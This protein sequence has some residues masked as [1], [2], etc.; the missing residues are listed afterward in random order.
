MRNTTKYLV[1]IALLL[2]GVTGSLFAQT[3]W[4]QGEMQVII[5]V[6]QAAIS[7]MK[8]LVERLS[9]NTE[10]AGNAIR[11]YVTA[12]ELTALENAGL[13]YQIEI[14]NLNAWSASFGPRGVPTGYYTL[15]ELNSIA[16]SL[17]LNFP[18]ICTI[19]TLGQATGFYQLMALKISD[20]SS[21]DENEAEVLFDG[22]IHGDEIGG[23]E[24]MIRFARDLC[25]QYGTDPDITELVN[26]REI[27]IYYCVNPYGR[28][29][30]TRYN[31]N[32][33]DINRD[34]G[35]M[36]NGEGNS[37]SAFS[38][39]ETRAYRKL[40]TEN[41]F[42]IHC[43]YHSGTEYISYPWSYRAEPTPDNAMHNYLAALY[44]SSSGYSNIPYAQGYNGMYAING[45]TK[46]FGYG[47]LGSISWS[48]EISL[49]KQ[50][51]S[52][53]IGSY[54]LKNKPSMLNM[55]EYAGYGIE[56]IVTD[57]ISGEPIPATLFIDNLFPFANDPETGD[58]HKFLLSGNYQV[59]V[60]SNGYES[61]II[62]G[63]TISSMTATE[64]NI[65]LPRLNQHFATRIIACQ[66]P[67]NN[68]MDEGFT[69]AAIGPPDHIRYSLGRFGYAILDM[70]D[71]LSDND[72]PEFIV[73]EYDATPEGYQLL[74]GQTMDGP[75]ILLGNATGTQE[76]DLA[77]SGL[78]SARYVKIKDDGDGS[79][80]EADAGFD[81]DA[82][83]GIVYLPPVDSTGFI[84]G[85]IYSLDFQE[86]IS[87]AIITCG[88]NSTFSTEEGS[89]TIMADTGIVELCSVY[90]PGMMNDC[91]TV[92]VS[93]GDTLIHDMYLPIT[94][95][96]HS[97]PKS[98]TNISLS[99]NPAGNFTILSYNGH[100]E[101]IHVKVFSADGRRTDCNTIAIDKSH[102]YLDTSRLKPGLY[103][104]RIQHNLIEEMLKFMIYR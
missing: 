65:A 48:V 1:F 22:G 62:S 19:H 71:T 44:A 61:R 59:K 86:P 52:S 33:I 74:A 57:S 42:V 96:I 36:W 95:A 64:V 98:E 7:T 49:S 13:K 70:G 63:V 99:P 24:N 84:S 53:Q 69:P 94:E 11:C 92:F 81:L 37:P 56:G 45:S 90:L 101:D 2:F 66:I 80:Q 35:Y 25:L 77:V 72:G 23:P 39:P 93:P 76:F 83:E 89:Y 5:P 87:G 40:L 103:I 29:N 60:V 27:W 10:T 21:V 51:P 68:V 46:D 32:G 9:I 55:V 17:A 54:Y 18:D 3:A 67:N 58:F 82:I 28:Q 6:D 12:S 31:A 16:D 43:S 88:I 85:I 20:N 47:A 15:D 104:V 50:P 41:Q 78:T 100:P 26:N 8:D 73:Y 34:C 75:W 4:R 14:D 38:Q 102:H 97:K 79:S 30:M 91:D